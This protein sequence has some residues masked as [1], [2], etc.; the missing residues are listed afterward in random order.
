MPWNRRHC[1]WSKSGSF[2][3]F[4]FE[5]EKPKLGGASAIPDLPPPCHNDHNNH[6]IY[7]FKVF[8]ISIIPITTCDSVSRLESWNLAASSLCIVSFAWVIMIVMIVINIVISNLS[9]LQ[10]EGYPNFVFNFCSV[11][12]VM[13]YR[14]NSQNK[15]EEEETKYQSSFLNDYFLNMSKKLIHLKVLGVPHTWF[16]F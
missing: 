1:L 12:K 10:G 15:L 2:L 7:H 9:L 5:S 11:F 3:V 4:T 6:N 8:I 13:F 14:L 16:L